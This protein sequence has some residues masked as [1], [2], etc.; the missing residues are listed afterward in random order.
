MN[1]KEYFEI[2][3]IKHIFT[4][5][6]H[7]RKALGAYVEDSF[8]IKKLKKEVATLFYPLKRGIYAIS[9][10]SIIL[11]CCFMKS[12]MEYYLI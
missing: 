7:R 12:I 8:T 10:I 11:N 6:G 4:L 9:T 5:I 1:K 3:N 2:E